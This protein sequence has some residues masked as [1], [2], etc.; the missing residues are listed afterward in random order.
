MGRNKKWSSTL[1]CLL[2]F[3]SSYFG[4]LDYF[5]NI[6]IDQSFWACAFPLHLSGISS[7]E[8]FPP[9]WRQHICHLQHQ[10]SWPRKE[11]S[12]GLG[13]L[14]EELGLFLCPQSA[15]GSCLFTV[16]FYCW[17]LERIGR[18][19]AVARAFNISVL[20]ALVSTLKIGFP[21]PY[22]WALLVQLLLQLCQCAEFVLQTATFFYTKFHPIIWKNI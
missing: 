16:K 6:L 21:V 5:W 9:C 17:K 4:C 3:I 12:L 22:I 19:W 14:F 15:E 13:Q 1:S 2:F 18:G 20:I 7:V 11:G 8:Q 10:I